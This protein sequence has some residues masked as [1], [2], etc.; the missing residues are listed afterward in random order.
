MLARLYY[1]NCYTSNLMPPHLSPLSHTARPAKCYFPLA[2][3][4]IRLP[5]PPPHLGIIRRPSGDTVQRVP[6]QKLDR[7][8]PYSNNTPCVLIYTQSRSSH[9]VRMLLALQRVCFN[10]RGLLRVC[11]RCQVVLPRWNFGVADSGRTAARTP[12]PTCWAAIGIGRCCT[13]IGRC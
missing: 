9:T 12:A 7:R 8:K 1:R 3:R 5:S 6:A 11:Q 10:Q 2:Q 4:T 13:G